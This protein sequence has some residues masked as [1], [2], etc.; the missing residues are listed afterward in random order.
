LKEL[1]IFLTLRATRD[2]GRERNITRESSSED[3]DDVGK[4][5][6]LDIKDVE[7]DRFLKEEKKEG[8]KSAVL[9]PRLIAKSDKSLERADEEKKKDKK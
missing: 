1:T 4:K 6:R 3:S 8:R 5:V 2:G 7:K 9:S